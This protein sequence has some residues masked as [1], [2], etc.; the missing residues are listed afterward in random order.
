MVGWAAARLAV[1]GYYILHCLQRTRHLTFAI[2]SMVLLRPYIL[3][4][5]RPP[6]L[7]PLTYATVKQAIDLIDEAAARVKLDLD[8]RPA[9]SEGRRTGVG[10]AQRGRLKSS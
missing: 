7:R 4:C 10:I 8:Q 5:S 2:S 3:E 6:A 1:D 9:V